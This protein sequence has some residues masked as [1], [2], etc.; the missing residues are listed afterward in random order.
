MD[1]ISPHRDLVVRRVSLDAL[2]PD[3]AN[4]RTHDEANL[5]AIKG[6]LARFG[7]AEPLILQAGTLRI[8][9]GHG[10]LTAMRA[11]E[12]TECEV[13]ELDVTDL[14]ATALG[15]A[16]NRSGE[17][18]GWDDGTLARLLAELRDDGGLDGVGFDD[19]DLDAL[20]DQL[21]RESDGLGG[22]PDE[23]PEPPD[24]PV[25]RPGDLWVLG[26]HRL[27]C[28]D[29][30]SPADLDRLLG[31]APVHLVNSDPPYNVRVEP[32]SNN[33]I[34]AGVSS[35]SQSHHQKLDLARHP[36]KAT[37]TTRKMR[38]KDRPLAND[39]VTDEAFD[40]LLAAWFGNIARVLLPGRGFYIW[41]G[42]A[43]C[44]NYPP[45][46]KANGLYF[47]QSI[48]WDK[49]HPVL[50]RKDFMGAHEWCQPAGTQV[51]TPHGEVPIES[52]RDGDR[53]VSYSRHHNAI[54]GVRKGKGVACTSR[55]YS[56]DLLGV[57]VG[58]STTWCTPGHLWTVRLTDRADAMWCV[59]LMKRGNWWRAGKSKLITSW[60]FGLKQ[61]LYTEG[62]EAAWI[63]S[64]HA[65]SLE[66]SLQEQVILAEYGIPLVTWS[67]SASSRRTISDVR[68]LYDRLDLDRM[69]DGANRALQDH[70][71]LIECPLLTHERTC[72]KVSRRVST[73]VRACNLL[74]GVMGVP[75]PAGRLEVDWPTLDHIDRERFDG[76]VYSME[77]EQ[78]GHYVADG[79]VTH[80]C[81]YGW[82]EGGA[83]Q[84]FGP[85]NATDLWAVKKVNPQSMVHLTEK[86]VELASR[87][88]LYSSRRG[89]NVLDLF[90]GS[91]ST[92]MACEETQ[93][94]GF[95]ME[96]D[97]PYADVIVMRWQQATG[98][99]A[100]LDGDGRT[101]AEVATERTP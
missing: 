81:F 44:A 29:S 91:G 82:K 40:E 72:T 89:E 26:D 100:V 71:R 46:L 12:W 39:F 83:H 13:V 31:G 65:S 7:Q 18:A 35:F 16:L 10:R 63:L 5:D 73:M 51:L 4:P 80:N 48:I 74:P 67:E 2:A 36:E 37:P 62:G 9:A 47:S 32:R 75:R 50:T 1:S 34:A 20:L 92:L 52:L 84:F 64:I 28:G 8:I 101:F 94:H 24:D 21:Q 3:P 42:Y 11:L 22:D 54:I 30:S 69:W 76:D 60:G 17:L 70:G 27:L 87:A 98:R 53:V 93:R 79:I 15:I 90:G 19:T 85:N 97:A 77:V 78:S 58:T 86:P 57:R 66:A 95:L 68:M 56:G 25:T 45:A 33:A 61:R 96:L 99:A 59:Y 23:I 38:A 14:E 88:I 41:G 6:S 43:N 55:Q 49:Q